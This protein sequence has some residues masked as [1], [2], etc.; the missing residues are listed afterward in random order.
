MLMT[1]NIEHLSADSF[2][3]LISEASKPKDLAAFNKGLSY[4]GI[5]SYGHFMMLSLDD[6]IKADTNPVSFWKGK[7]K[8]HLDNQMVSADNPAMPIKLIKVILGTI[9]FLR[10]QGRMS[11]QLFSYLVYSEKEKHQL[12]AEEMYFQFEK[13]LPFSKD[14]KVFST[15][16]EMRNFALKERTRVTISLNEVIKL[17]NLML[18]LN[19]S[20]SQTNILVNNLIGR[21]FL[22]SSSHHKMSNFILLSENTKIVWLRNAP[23]LFYLF[24]CLERYMPN[25]NS[26][27]S[28]SPTIVQQL[29]SIFINEKGNLISTET[30]KKAYQRLNLAKST[31]QQLSIA[32][33]KKYKE[34]YEIVKLLELD[35]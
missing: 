14:Y 16:T 6:A 9:Y 33:G 13:M 7:F 19:L 12:A 8:K 17:P 28:D 5:E 25:I 21:K 15:M 27:I 2:N 24:W 10:Y 1:E 20:E 4:L 26:I 18:K 29:S 22:A 34:I 30:L 11:T 35:N 23:E 3:Q 31:C 32:K